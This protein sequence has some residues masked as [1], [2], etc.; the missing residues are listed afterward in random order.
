[1][2][3]G[4]L[5]NKQF[6]TIA[7]IIILCGIAIVGHDYFVS[8]K[9]NSYEKMSI[10]LSQEPEYVEE[11]SESENVVSNNNTNVSTPSVDK[12]KPTTV[13]YNY[14]G[15]LKIPEI[16]FNRG[17]V[18][19][20]AYGNNVDQNIAILSGSTYPDDAYSNFILAGHNGSRWNAF[21]KD[22]DKLS[23]G[24]NA[25]I[26]YKGKQY[27]YTLVK[28]YSDRQGDGVVLYRHSG[29]K[30]LTLI[31]CKRP[32]YHT[33]YLVLVFELSNEKNM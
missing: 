28:S 31:T 2:G 21:F 30:Q 23:L 20:G 7:L 29:K 11:V 13:T 27:T 19:Y 16:N 24:D 10:L 32:D 15:R 26:V 9:F 3:D 1:M 5:S 14:I 4:K 17:F 25:Y 22:I 18:K 8:K 6:V 12:K 33:Y